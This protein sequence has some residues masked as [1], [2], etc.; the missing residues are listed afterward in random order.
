MRHVNVGILVLSPAHS[1]TN[2]SD[3]GRKAVR[4]ALAVK[5]GRGVF[6]RQPVRPGDLLQMHISSEY[7]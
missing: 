7:S 5:S 3:Q 6:R 1:I 2:E 4:T